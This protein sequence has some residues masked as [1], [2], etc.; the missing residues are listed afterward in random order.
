MR[1]GSAVRG[2]SSLV[3]FTRNPHQNWIRIMLFSSSAFE[4][5]SKNKLFHYFFGLLLTVGT[6]TTVYI[7]YNLF[8]KSQTVEY[9]T[10]LWLF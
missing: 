8:K 10:F 4:M 9:K 1:G 5:P 2:Y 7:Y 6:F 3:A